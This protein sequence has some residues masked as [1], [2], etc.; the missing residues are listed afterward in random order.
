ME[1]SLDDCVGDGRQVLPRI[2]GKDDVGDRAAVEGV[3]IRELGGIARC[4]TA[5]KGGTEKVLQL[6]PVS[7]SCFARSTGYFA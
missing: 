3:S 2:Y 1:L 5:A 6:S 4:T 7:Q